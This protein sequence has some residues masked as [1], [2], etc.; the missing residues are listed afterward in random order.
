MLTEEQVL[1][2]KAKHGDRL[3][4][5]EFP[6]E[7]V[8]KAPPRRIWAEFQDAIS[9]DNKGTREHAYRRLVLQCCVHPE[10][11]ADAESV[12]NDYPALPTKIGDQLGE[13]VGIGDEIEVKK[14]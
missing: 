1:D 3:I 6:T 5:V 14:L 4:A 9:K 8:F 12:F 11:Q 10:R 13:L 7:M 2:L